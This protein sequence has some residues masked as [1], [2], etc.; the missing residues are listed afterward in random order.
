MT[1]N[2]ALNEYEKAWKDAQK[3]YKECLQRGV[4]ANPL[5]L[6]EIIDPELCET[7]VR[8][9]LVE[10]PLRQIV[11]TKTAGRITAFTPSFRPLLEPETEFALKWV[12][13]CQAHLGD[14]G[15]KDPIECYEYMGNFYV[16]EGNKRVSVLQ[17]FG[18]ARVA[19]NVLRIPPV[20]DD[21]PRYKAYMEFVEFY[22]LTG[23]YD[24][25]YSQPGNYAK[26][27]EKI[28][29]SPTQKWTE[30][31]RRSFRASIQYFYEALKAVCNTPARP[32]ME[33]ALLL[34]LDVYPFTDLKQRTMA[35]LKKTI[36]LMWPNLVAASAP[37][38]VVKT[39]PPEEKNKIIQ[40]FKGMSHVN[41]AFVHQRN[42]GNSHWTCAHEKGREYLES[43]MG[44]E[45]T[46]RVYPDADT[47]E[48]AEE[49]LELAVAE[50]AEVVFATAP[51][52]IGPSMKVSVKYPK[53]RFLNCSLRQPYASVRTYYSRIYEGK[54]I[55]GAIAGAMCKG[56]RIGY[57]GYYP[58]RGVPASINAFALG[59]QLTNPDARIVLRWSCVPGN[60]TQDLL[61]EGIHVIS[62]RDTPIG[63]ELAGAYGTYIADENGRLTQLGSPTWGWGQFY[64]NMIRSIMKGNWE[65]EKAGKIVNLWWGLRSG[66]MDVALSPDLPE[67]IRTLANFLK[68][69]ITGG[70]LDPFRRKI[71]DQAG[72]VR[73]DGT[74]TFSPVELME[75][76]W[77]CENVEGG[78]PKYEEL[79]EVAKT[80]VDVLGVEASADEAGAL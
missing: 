23:L 79:V 62:N 67:G 35:E 49:L 2:D 71:L 32:N 11:G 60:A 59:A 1:R 28:G 52:L 65:D 72:N 20:P 58:T 80:V 26:L 70:F 78:F 66:V 5:V 9:G 46:T 61:G 44:R 45:I 16:Q 7:S 63:N 37:E 54:F 21:S 17:H 15:I 77:L 39:E 3:E 4:R 36:T 76:D 75:M 18:A 13:L 68:Q 64:E 55:T 30:D 10:I 19:A 41:V 8:V 73:N 56:N 38:T 53:V 47:P 40:I 34:W 50:G 69:G 12:N 48:R 51:Q 14:E 29:K 42:A 6:E 74:K 22:K 25:Q 33:D 31:D 43:V 27:L 24:I 57:V